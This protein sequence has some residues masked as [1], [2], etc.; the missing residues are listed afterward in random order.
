MSTSSLYSNHCNGGW[1]QTECISTRRRSD[2][3][4]LLDLIQS[5]E[6]RDHHPVL[7]SDQNLQFL[8]LGLHTWQ[9]P[10][11]D[12]AKMLIEGSYAHRRFV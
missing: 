5:L 9:F 8:F 12:R 6:D 3:T 2:C 4:V 10:G 7:P 11:E 1:F